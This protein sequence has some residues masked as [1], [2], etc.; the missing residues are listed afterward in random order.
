[1]KLNLRNRF[2]VPTAGTLV[3]AF[4]AYM[5]VTS[6]EARKALQA[7]VH[8][9]MG[10]I[11]RLVQGQLSSWL[12]HRELDV[13]RWSELPSLREA[14]ARPDSAAL[15]AAAGAL[16]VD[17]AEHT[18]D[19]EGLH[20]VRS[21]GLTIASSVSGMAGTLNIADREYFKACLQTN[22]GT[23]SDAVASRVT[24]NP[25]VVF[26]EPVRSPDGRVAGAIIGV[27]DLKRFADNVI[28]PIKVGATGYAFVCAQDGTFLSH[29]KQELILKSKVTEWDF[30]KRIMAEGNGLLAYNFKGVDRQA[31]FSRDD[32]TGWVTAIA[33]DESQIF[34]AADRLRN[35]GFILTLVAL[36]LTCGVV[37][38][39]TR[40][41]TRPINL[42]IAQLNTGS[43][44]TTTAA[45]EIANA[46]VM[47]AN[48]S[49]EQA[50]AVEE[51]SASLE[52]MSATV[53]QTTLAADDCQNLM[54]QS[55]AV[56]EQGLSSMEQMVEAIDTIKGSADRTAR[57]VKTIDEIAFQTNL[58]ALNAAVEAARAGEAG[59]G[60]AVVAEEVRNLAQRAASAA[61]ETSE[62][63]EQSVT[64]A[65]RGVH[66][67]AG[68]RAA[69]T[70][71]AG[72]AT[73]VAAQVDR[74]AAAARE[75]AEGIDQIG[76]AMRQ[77]D[78]TTQGAAAS[79]EETASAAEEL[80][81]QAVELRSIVAKLQ[82]LVT[83]QPAAVSRPVAMPAPKA[84]LSSRRLHA[85]A[86]SGRPSASPARTAP[87]APAKTH[88]QEVFALD[89]SEF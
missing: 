74:I 39:V 31:A 16:L 20:L 80:N 45:T 65:D 56:V 47:L 59:K 78:E 54:R 37:V 9:E 85:L 49:S 60:F 82:A 21:D 13:K 32:R 68:A 22:K 30:G 64:H 38:L 34:A 43:D 19:Y 10:Q 87:R 15:A 89:D 67:T 57:I 23:L 44:Q 81:A 71:T 41:V 14:V 58:L 6:F 12:D 69:F 83:G 61:R 18:T 52:E 29:P 26:C 75:Q 50:A 72:N 63:I 76:K 3:I 48:Q 51:T 53:K 17:Q 62:L 33:L 5:A 70:A 28:N 73:Q 24:G 2:L 27:V 36:A 66:V 77:V 11:N 7:G 25:I 42:M 35:I 84:A 55:Q 4:C 88:A 86:D 1:M 46:S 8:D 79:A 40:S